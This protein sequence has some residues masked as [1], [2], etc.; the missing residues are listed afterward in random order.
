MKT[1]GLDFFHISGFLCFLLYSCPREEY[2]SGPKGD[3]EGAN[4]IWAVCIIY[5]AYPVIVVGGIYAGYFSPTEAAAVTVTYAVILEIVIY[6]S[7]SL[8]A[9]PSIALSTGVVFF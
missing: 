4:N 6:R 1:V 9:I 7:F 8:K 5:V 3:L 2:T